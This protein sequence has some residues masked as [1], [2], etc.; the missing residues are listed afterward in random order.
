[1]KPIKLLITLLL[2]GL[3]VWIGR[4]MAHS[5]VPQ[6]EGRWREIGPE[7]LRLKG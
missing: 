3:G 5:K 4:L 2:L 6:P 1:M 7:E